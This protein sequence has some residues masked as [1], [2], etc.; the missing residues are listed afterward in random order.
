MKSPDQA[1]DRHF[2][3]ADSFAQAFDEA[4]KIQPGPA[5]GTT[6]TTEE[7]LDHVLE[8]VHDHPFAMATPDLARQVARFRIRLLSL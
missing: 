1:T 4:W 6:M 2:N 7:K 3:N 8:S 5:S